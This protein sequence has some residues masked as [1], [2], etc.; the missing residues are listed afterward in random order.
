MRRYPI[1][2]NCKNDLLCWKDWVPVGLVESDYFW[3]LPC[4][5][6]KEPFLIKAITR[7]EFI[8]KSMKVPATET[9][10]KKVV[11]TGDM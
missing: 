7:I 3:K 9:V 11:L 5:E 8:V 2:P 4:P 1:C 6:C 10:N